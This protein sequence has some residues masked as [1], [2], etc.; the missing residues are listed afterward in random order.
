MIT[1]KAIFSNGLIEP[2]ELLNFP[3]GTKM[4]ITIDEESLT[5]SREKYLE[6]ISKTAGSWKDIDADTLLEDIY[7]SRSINTREIPKL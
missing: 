2:L 4:T 3:E 1:I 6:V 7:N 5:V